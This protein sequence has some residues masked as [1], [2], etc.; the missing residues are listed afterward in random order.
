MT[1]TSNT[2]LPVRCLAD[3]Q[4]GYI[5]STNTTAT[6]DPWVAGQI[7]WA[8]CHQQGHSDAQCRTILDGG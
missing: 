1:T 3:D 6:Q 7:A 4:Q 8:A 2:G 5:W